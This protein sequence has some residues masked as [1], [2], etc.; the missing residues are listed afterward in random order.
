VLLFH[1]KASIICISSNDGLWND[2]DI[3]EGKRRI[4]YFD[5]VIAD[6]D[7]ITTTLDLK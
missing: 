5:C 7:M 6:N 3:T 4:S 1:N 2:V